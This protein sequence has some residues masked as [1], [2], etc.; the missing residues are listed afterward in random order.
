MFKLNVKIAEDKIVREL[1][2]NRIVFTTEP[3]PVF[4]SVAGTKTD[5]KLSLYE[6]LTNHYVVLK[7]KKLDEDVIK[8]ICE[9]LENSKDIEQI[10]EGLRLLEDNI[11]K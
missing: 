5:K 8:E 11:N 2:N 6:Q 7:G 9:T 3:T 4:D 1:I 10:E